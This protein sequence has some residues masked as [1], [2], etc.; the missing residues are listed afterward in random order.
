MPVLNPIHIDD[1]LTQFS[2]QQFTTQDFI[3]QFR[4]NYPDDWNLLQ[5]RYGRGGSGGGTR[6]SANSYIALRLYDRQSR[7]ELILS[8]YEQSPE[9]WGNEV[10]AR[11]Q[12]D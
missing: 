11:W 12:K 9:G 8:G 7:N 6:Y 10:I 2:G 4:V 5:E 3:L 1:V